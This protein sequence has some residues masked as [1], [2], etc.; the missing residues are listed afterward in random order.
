MAECHPVGFQWVMEAKARGA[1]VIHVDPRFTRTSARRRPA[2]PVAGRYRHRVPRRPDQPRPDRRARTS[3][4]TSWPTPTPPDPGG[5][6]PRHRGPRRPVL[7]FRPGDRAPTTRPAGST[8]ASRT[9]PPPDSA[10]PEA[11]SAQRERVSRGERR[12]GSHGSGGPS[13][14]GTRSPTRP[15]SIRAACS[16]CSSG[17]SPATPRNW[18]SEV[19]GISPEL[20][21]RVA[22]ALTRNSGRERTTAFVL[23]G[24]LDPPHGRR[25]V[26]PRRGDHA[27]AAGQHRPPGRRDP[28]AARARQHPGLHRHPDA[29]QHP[30]R[31]HP[32]AARRTST[33]PS[34]TSSPPTPAT[35]GFWGN[36]DAY[37]VSLLKAWWGDAAT[38]EN[39]FCFDYLP[40]LTG[41]HGTYDTVMRQL[42]ADAAATSC[43]GENPA[44]GSAQ[45]EDA[46]AGHGEAGLARR[47]RPRHDR[48]RHVLAGRA[49]DRDRRAAHRGHRHRGVLPARRGPHGE[50]R[51]FHQDP[52]D[53]AVAPQ[54][55]R[56][57]RRRAQRAV[58]LLPPRPDHPASGWPAPPTARTGR[59]WT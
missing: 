39:D 45:R 17:T 55:R 9:R 43:V 34:P 14:S 16:R 50:G 53:A 31:L 5:G 32:D 1:T 33:R 24:R 48:E 42:D 56:A 40:R 47:P 46:A 10:T 2:C 20:F 12:G 29:V 44:V 36:M 19:C 37:T 58:V 57:A 28:G 49:G 54:G 21:A 30:A 3:A 23:R 11:A 59:C 8:R 38:A 35:K 26:H 15:C 27:D 51:Q 41:D 4:S 52:T 6:F 22:E 25:P 18:S 7:R 13:L